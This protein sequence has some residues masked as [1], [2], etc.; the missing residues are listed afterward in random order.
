MKKKLL[1]LTTAILLLV[2][3]SFEINAQP[4]LDNSFSGD[5]YLLNKV[6]A[7]GDDIPR[8]VLI[9][10]NGRILTGG[11]SFD[12]I[13]YSDIHIMRT[14][15]NGSMDQTFGTAGIATIPGGFFCDMALLPG[16]KIIVAGSGVGPTNVNNFIVYRLTKTGL[17]DTTFGNGG[18][19][20]VNIP[21]Q[22]MICFDVVIQSD[23]K[24]L[25]GGYV[26]GYANNDM[27]VVRLKA[28]GNIDNTFATGGKFI[29][30]QTS[31]NSECRQIALQADGKIIVG[32]AIDTL[33]FTAF[34][35]YDYAALRLTTNGTL[36]NTF[37]VGV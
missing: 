19:V 6:S 16:G 20:E 28:N 17:L 36:D 15:A 30:L 12:Q 27:L 5:G 14:K 10:S 31:K 22:S 24:I 37:G 25:L 21:N 1:H 23:G 2:T 9:Q 4:V 32:G 34:L 8:T 7:A 33:V 18:S 26:G 3:I 11:N 13:G 29:F 35:R